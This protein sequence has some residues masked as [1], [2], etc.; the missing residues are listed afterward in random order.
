MIFT[1]GPMGEFVVRKNFFFSS[2][3]FPFGGLVFGSDLF[4][5]FYGIVV[6]ITQVFWRP[7]GLLVDQFDSKSDLINAVITSSFIPG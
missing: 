3:W 4:R 2:I 1:L 6:A 5:S 7:R